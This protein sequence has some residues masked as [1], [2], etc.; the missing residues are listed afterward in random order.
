MNPQP[1]KGRFVLQRSDLGNPNIHENHRRMIVDIANVDFP[2]VFGRRT[3]LD[4]VGHRVT[5]VPRDLLNRISA[6]VTDST[7]QPYARQQFSSR[8]SPKW[9]KPGRNKVI[10]VPQK[11]RILLSDVSPA[12]Q[13][14]R[15]PPQCQV[16]HEDCLLFVPQ[17]VFL[18]N[19]NLRTISSL[20]P[21]S[22]T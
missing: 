13:T 2:M 1:D 9:H 3:R 12:T 20:C 7:T 8:S 17:F 10:R 21:R 5:F 14:G 11:T 19:K 4:F 18:S 15:S 6:S 16:L 22:D